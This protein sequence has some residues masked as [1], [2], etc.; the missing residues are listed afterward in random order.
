MPTSFVSLIT[1]YLWGMH[2]LNEMEGYSEELMDRIIEVRNSIIETYNT[3]VFSLTYYTNMTKADVDN[4]L[5][6]ELEH[7]Y[8]LLVKQKEMEKPKE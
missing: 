7:M 8:K 5:P 2:R 1:M 6:Y 3:K 4:M